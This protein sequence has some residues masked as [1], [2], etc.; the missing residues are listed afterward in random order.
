MS[1][2]DVGVDAGRWYSVMELLEGETLRKRLARSALNW[3]KASAIGSA[4]ADGL[5]AAHARGIVHLDVKPENISLTAS[6]GVKILDFGISRSP[7]DQHQGEGQSRS[8]DTSVQRWPSTC[9]SAR[10]PSC[11]SS[12]TQSG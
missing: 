7:F 8:R 1:I 4:I 5:A 3:R 6:G 10:N 11:L 2:H 12:K 9:A